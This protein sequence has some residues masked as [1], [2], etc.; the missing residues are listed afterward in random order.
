MSFNKYFIPDNEVM[1][2]ILNVDKTEDHMSFG[3]TTIFNDFFDELN[4]NTIFNIIEYKLWLR[5]INLF[6]FFY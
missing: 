5:A 4:N 6:L 3:N 2:S 1:L